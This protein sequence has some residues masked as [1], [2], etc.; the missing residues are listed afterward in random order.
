MSRFVLPLIFNA[1]FEE[2]RKFLFPDEHLPLIFSIGVRA[3]MVQQLDIILTR[4]ISTRF[5]ISC[6][7]QRAP[8]SPVSVAGELIFF[9]RF[10][11]S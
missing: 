10:E 4:F 1:P 2:T 11:P 8:S 7:A 5:R 9:V 6:F 3:T